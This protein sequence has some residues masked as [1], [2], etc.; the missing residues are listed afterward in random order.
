MCALNSSQFI[1]PA[2]LE[3]V[4]TRPLPMHPGSMV[5][6]QG[7]KWKAVKEDPGRLGWEWERIGGIPSKYGSKYGFF[8][9]D[10]PIYDM[11][12]FNH[13]VLPRRQPL[14]D[15]RKAQEMGVLPPEVVDAES[16]YK[17]AKV[18]PG[19]TAGEHY[20]K[21]EPRFAYLYARDVLGGRFSLG[22]PAMKTSPEYWARYTSM[23]SRLVSK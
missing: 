9:Y 19:W 2:L 23:I 5:D 12:R 20:I 14:K 4:K 8:K 16:A 7:T 17:Y 18:H 11:E 22:E 1:K 15:T 21:H 13:E 3:A 10:H 6:Y